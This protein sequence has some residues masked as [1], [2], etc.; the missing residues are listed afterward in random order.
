LLHNYDHVLVPEMN[1]GQLLQLIRAKYLVPAKGLSKV[2][3]QPFTTAE[4]RNSM[5]ELLNEL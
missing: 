1:S 5:M 2:Q 4:I 3:G